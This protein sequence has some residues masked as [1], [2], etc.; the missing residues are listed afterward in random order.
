MVYQNST[1]SSMPREALSCTISVNFYP[2]R[3]RKLPDHFENPRAFVVVNL[4]L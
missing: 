3:R 4:H 1:T 2:T